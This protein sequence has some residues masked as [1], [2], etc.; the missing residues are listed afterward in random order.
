MP[1]RLGG[2][3]VFAGVGQLVQQRRPHLRRL[4]QRLQS[5]VQ[6]FAATMDIT[7]EQSGSPTWLDRQDPEP[8]DECI[9]PG[10]IKT[11]EDP[12]DKGI[13]DTEFLRRIMNG[14]EELQEGA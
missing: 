5:D 11:G 12:C 10:L 2:S 14:P 3:Q 8:T 1:A 6:R 7:A 9:G 13:P 4:L